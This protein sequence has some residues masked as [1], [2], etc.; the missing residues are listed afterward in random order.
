MSIAK[1]QSIELTVLK[2]QLELETYWSI[3][4]AWPRNFTFEAGD[5]IDIAFKNQNLKGGVT[6]SLSSSPTE[7]QLRITFRRGISQ[8][9]Q[10]LQSLSRND[11][12]C[13]TQFGNGYKFQLN[14]NRSS[15]L[16]AGGIGIAPFRSMIKEMYDQ[17]G[18]SE[19]T[20]IYLTPT[21]H[22]LFK[23]ELAAWQKQL[24]NL[25][26][27]HIYTK[28]LNQKKRHK[29]LASLIKNANQNFYIAGPPTM[30]DDTEH[31]LID[32]GV[33]MQAIRIDIFGGY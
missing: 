24:S 9:K 29:S 20:L 23:D 25:T 5:W 4:F 19:V 33:K 14:R 10:A 26:I 16:I 13:V 6:Y 11:K 2:R 17:A 7:S 1:N 30:V 22:C 27:E 21:Q 12:V 3:Y 8:L 31:L 15:V 28:N 32:L 18:N